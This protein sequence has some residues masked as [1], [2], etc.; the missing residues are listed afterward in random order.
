LIEAAQRLTGDFHVQICGDLNVS[1]AYSGR[2]QRAAAGLPVEFTGAFDRDDLPRIYG[3][4]DVLVVPS[5]WPENSPLVIHEAFM[6]GV[7]VVGANQGGIPELVT[8]GVNG[9]IYEPQSP[10]ALAAALQR[11]LDDP[12]LASA[13]AASAPVIKT[14]AQDACEWEARYEEVMTTGGLH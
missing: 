11:F 5:L 3:G 14:I 1:P 10:G 7:A 6:H 9:L 12:D 4:L 13:Y 2:L 8:D